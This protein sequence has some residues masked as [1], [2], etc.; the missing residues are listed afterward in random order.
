MPY[1]KRELREYVKHGRTEAIWAAEAEYILAESQ[2]ATPEAVARRRRFIERYRGGHPYPLQ[3]MD[4]EVVWNADL[5]EKPP[6]ER[7]IGHPDDPRPLAVIPNRAYSE[8]FWFRGRDPHENR[9]RI[10]DY[11][12]RAVIERDWPW[13][14]ICGGL[15]A[16]GEH[17]LDHIHPYS[18]GGPASV[19]NLQL[20]HD[21]CNIR[22]GARIDGS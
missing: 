20:T 14:Q 6:S 19:E 9:P 17:H 7:Y 1:T 21:L 13:C 16:L 5:P 3:F 11:I 10:P 22:K 2:V 12:K 8:W 4:I 18:Q 15:V